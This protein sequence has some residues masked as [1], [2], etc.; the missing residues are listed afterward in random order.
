MIRQLINLPRD[1]K[2]IIACSGGVDSMAV[3]DFYRQGNKQFELAYFDHR[4][5]NNIGAIPAIQTY[6]SKYNINLHI[7]EL[8]STKPKEL[9]IE[10]HWRN[11][12]YSFL[13]SFGLP[14]VTCHHLNDAAET[15]LMTSIHGQGRIIPPINDNVYRPFLLNTKQELIDWCL[16]HNVAWFEDESN[17]NVDYSRNR[18]R[19]NILPETLKINPGFLKVIKKKYLNEKH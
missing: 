10:E 13:R 6:A 3:V 9:S 17:Q 12:R 4:T 11:E 18:V 2:F 19:H 14:I 15:W 1:K 16:R 7:G 5:G 8:S